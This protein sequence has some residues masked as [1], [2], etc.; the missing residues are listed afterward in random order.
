MSP[1]PDLTWSA[2]PLSAEEAATASI[3]DAIL[4]GRLVPGQRLA[5]AE[6]AA[7]LGVSRIPLRDA[8]RRL[9]GDLVTIDGRR[10]CWVTSLGIGEIKEIYEIRIALES[11]CATLA[12]TG[13]SDQ[14]ARHLFGL[15]EQMDR[16]QSGSP[17][18]YRARRA[19]YA[20]LYSHA[21][22]PRMRGL[23]LQ[24]RDNVGRYHVLK[25][26]RHSVDAHEQL[27]SHI[28]DRNPG[29]AAEVV[30]AHLEE[31][32]DDLLATMVQDE[33]LAA[34]ATEES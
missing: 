30:V 29:G 9:D 21:N 25:D 24:L 2:E 13:L 18:V 31:T 6:L 10:G 4:S 1:V 5:Q 16:T 26:V 22:R 8:L 7:Q 14:E 11:R 27:R 32:R 15:S 3:R 20:E 33:H 17:L 23:I 12:V 19:F 28:M 34:L